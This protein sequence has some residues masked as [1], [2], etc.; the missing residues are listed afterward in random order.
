MALKPKRTKKHWIPVV[1]GLLKRGSQVLVGQRPD[2]H[3]L[4]G[5]WEFPGEK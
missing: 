3:S 5:Q 4:A 2:N 1:A